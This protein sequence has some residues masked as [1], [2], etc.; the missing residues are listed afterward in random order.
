MARWIRRLLFPQVVEKQLDAELHFH[1]EQQVAEY[2]A[3]GMSPEEANRRAQ[4]GL[5]GVEQVKQKCRERRWENRVESVVR[6]IRFA[7]R[8]LLR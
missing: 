6:D 1:L 5:G 7:I 4:I 8:R 2:V 3:L